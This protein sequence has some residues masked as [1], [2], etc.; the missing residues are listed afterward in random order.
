MGDALNDVL[1]EEVLSY[2]QARVLDLGDELEK[3][4]EAG[5]V[6]AKDKERAKIIIEAV[7]VVLARREGTKTAKASSAKAT[8]PSK[9]EPGKSI[10]PRFRGVLTQTAYQCIQK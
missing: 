2:F 1:F 8:E 3:S 9:V 7:T 5:D 6:I 4:I 10:E